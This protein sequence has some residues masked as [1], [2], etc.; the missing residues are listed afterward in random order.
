MKVGIM[1]GSY[2]GNVE[3]ND[4]SKIVIEALTMKPYT[5]VKGA[6]TD[7]T[8]GIV[9]E[10]ARENGREIVSIGN[11]FEIRR[12]TADIKIPVNSTFE[13]LEKLYENSDIII[14][15]DGGTGTISEFL[16]FL[17]NKIETEGDKPLI[18]YNPNGIYNL[19]LKDLEQ[20]KRLGLIRDN[21]KDYFDEAKNLNH[22]AYY[23]EKYENKFNKES[24]ERR[25]VR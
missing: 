11:S 20:R 2:P 21:Y 25:K 6:G 22:L 14:F 13:R 9:E 10:I 3:V 7:G 19:L 16:S 5:I 12:S 8:M 23:L 24:D 15:L 4:S 1:C 18:L 17:N